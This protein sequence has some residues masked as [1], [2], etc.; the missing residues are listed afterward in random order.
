MILRKNKGTA[1]IVV[2]M[3]MAV[4]TILGVAILNISLSQASNEEKRIQAHYLAHSGAEATLSAWEML[5]VI[6]NQVENV[7]LYS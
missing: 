5:R 2:I 3:V 7:S 6:I 4:M 1:L